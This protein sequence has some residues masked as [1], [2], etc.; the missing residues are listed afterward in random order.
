PPRDL[1]PPVDGQRNAGPTPQTAEIAH[2][3]AVPEER[4]TSDLIVVAGAR[5]EGR[6]AHHL[7]APVHGH[8]MAVRAA[9]GA[10]ALHGRPVPEERQLL[11]RKESRREARDLSSRVEG[12]RGAEP[13]RWIPGPSVPPPGTE[14]L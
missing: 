5:G 12:R 3:R 14:H 4:M 10:E 6:L 1:T 11:R 9:Q 13:G 7:A 8:G 2:R